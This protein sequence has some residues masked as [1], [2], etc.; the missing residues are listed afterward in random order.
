[1]K[2]DAAAKES[3][4]SKPAGHDEPQRVPEVG[5]IQAHKCTDCT[6]DSHRVT[7]SS[8]YNGEI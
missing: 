3:S 7:L 1:M 4:E 8:L 6:A 5:A 2:R